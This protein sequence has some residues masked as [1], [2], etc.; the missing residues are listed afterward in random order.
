[1]GHLEARLQQSLGTAVKLERSRKGGR[2]VIR[3]YGDEDL[4]A[5]IERLLGEEG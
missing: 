1:L 2:I 4:Q 3:F 5:L